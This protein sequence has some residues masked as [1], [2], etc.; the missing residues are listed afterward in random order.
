MSRIRQ[1][2]PSTDSFHLE[3]LDERARTGAITVTNVESEEDGSGRPALEANVILIAH[4]ENARLGTR[5]RLVSGAALEIGR[6]DSVE[7]SLPEVRS[8][9]R[10]HARL[11]YQGRKVTVEDAGSTNGTFVNDQRVDG[12]TLLRSGDRFQ[13]GSVHF[14]FLHEQDVEHAYHEAIYQMVM[15]D[16]LTEALNQRKF[17]E[18]LAREFARASRHDR[19][20]SLVLF[21][22]DSFKEVND[23]HGHLCGDMVL[24]Q[25]AASVREH[26]RSEQVFARLGGDEFAVL[27]PETGIQGGQALAEKLRARLSDLSFA[28]EGKLFAVT[29]SFGIAERLP[30]MASEQSLFEAADRAL[31]SAKGAGR[32]RVAPQDSAAAASAPPAPPAPAAPPAPP[33]DPASKPD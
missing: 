27:C 2:Q 30:D 23:T 4:P 1:R 10:S 20:L 17:H 19:P 6:S 12:P 3:E 31:Y 29:C 16:G 26:V 14:K 33:E 8:I 24:K 13:V 15:R 18:E 25:V 21:D 11:R 7:I 22:I 32:N 28:R 9:S 5:Y